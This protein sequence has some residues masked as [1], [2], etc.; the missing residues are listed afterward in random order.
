MKTRVLLAL[1]LIL[2][3][4]LS[5]SAATIAKIDKINVGGNGKHGTFISL[6]GKSFSECLNGSQSVKSLFLSADPSVNPNYKEQLSV[7]LAAKISD[8]EIIV[9]YELCDG[10]YPVINE[11]TLQ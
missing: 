2:G 6:I 9:S 7:A 5:Y 10:N 8:K 1:S 4:P 11:V 3:S